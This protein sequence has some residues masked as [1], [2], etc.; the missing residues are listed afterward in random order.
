MKTKTAAH[1]QQPWLKRVLIPFWTIQ[2]LFMLILIG[3]ASFVVYE[4]AFQT[5]QG[6]VDLVLAFACINM[7][8]IIVEIALFI[9]RGLKPLTYLVMQV[10]KTT[11]WAVLFFISVAGIAIASSRDT[12]TTNRVYVLGGIIQVVVVL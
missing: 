8:L 9:R 5:S 3:L 11:I 1:Y 12:L 2:S 7:T 4:T 6:G 10:L